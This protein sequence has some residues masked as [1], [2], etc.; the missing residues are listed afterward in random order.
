MDKLFVERYADL[1]DHVTLGEYYPAILITKAVPAGAEIL[2]STYGAGYWARIRKERT[3]QRHNSDTR[4][5]T[6]TFVTPQERAL[7]HKHSAEQL[8]RSCRGARKRKRREFEEES[9]SL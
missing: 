8:E 3:W 6:R 9:P 5:V 2:L 7:L 4:L 1:A